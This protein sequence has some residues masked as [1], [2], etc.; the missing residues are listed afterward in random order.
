MYS[1]T[2]SEDLAII[3]D[4]FGA[5]KQEIISDYMLLD[6]AESKKFWSVYNEYESERV[7]LINKRIEKLRKFYDENAEF[8][9]ETAKSITMDLLDSDIAKAELHKKYFKKMTTAVGA[10]TAAKFFQ[11]ENYIENS[12]QLS[13]QENI[14]FIGDLEGMELLDISEDAN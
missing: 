13:I 10:Y 9:D 3:M 1:Q 7:G 11:I 5:S 4:I 2:K 12:V 6:D 14:P 8:D